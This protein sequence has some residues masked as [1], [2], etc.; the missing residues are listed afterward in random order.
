MGNKFCKIDNDVLTDNNLQPLSC[1]KDTNKCKISNIDGIIDG[2]IPDHNLEKSFVETDINCN[3]DDYGKITTDIKNINMNNYKRTKYDSVNAPKLEG[4]DASNDP[5]NE[6]SFYLAYQ[7]AIENNN[8]LNIDLLKSRHTFAKKLFKEVS[9]STSSSSNTKTDDQPKI[10]HKLKALPYYD[11]MPYSKNKDDEN[12][13]MYIVLI[14]FSLIT[15]IFLV[16][17]GVLLFINSN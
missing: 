14:V 2:T 10:I 11:I 1:F 6:A 15:T 12:D 7:G 3:Y 5:N 9:T 4:L 17:F 8:E 16:L 13:I